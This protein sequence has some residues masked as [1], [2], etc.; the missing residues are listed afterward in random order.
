MYYTWTEQWTL[1][2]SLLT[3]ASLFILHSYH[4][5]S[6]F[7]HCRRALEI[8]TNDYTLSKKLRV[9]ATTLTNKKHNVLVAMKK[10]QSDGVNVGSVR[11]EDIVSGHREKT[12]VLLWAL[13]HGYQ[14]RAA[15][16]A[17]LLSVVGAVSK[18]CELLCN[19]LILGEKQY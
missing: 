6:A 4:W 10:L 8:L 11:A 9:P 15:P 18:N 1:I 13:I 5:W 12:L 17:R 3:G 14:V 16:R 19:I 7:S 2:S